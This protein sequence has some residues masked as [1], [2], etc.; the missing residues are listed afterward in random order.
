M[1][2]Y[3]VIDNL[4]YYLL[5]AMTIGYGYIAFQRFR[6]Y[7]KCRHECSCSSARSVSNF[8]GNVPQGGI[9]PHAKLYCNVLGIDNV[10]PP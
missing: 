10:M 8:N 4:L 1:G 3:L 2:V 7:R 6:G 5:M 9:Y